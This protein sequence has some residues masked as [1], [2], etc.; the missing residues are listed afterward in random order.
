[1]I[2]LNLNLSSANLENHFIYFS[3]LFIYLPL[4]LITYKFYCLILLH[5]L[6][7]L[8][9][10]C[11]LIFCVLLVATVDMTL[12]SLIFASLVSDM[13]FI[14]LVIYFTLGSMCFKSLHS[15]FEFLYLPFLSSSYSCFFLYLLEHVE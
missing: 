6:S 2:L 8:C 13:L 7:M 4:I 1:M 3:I 9:N 15:P 10:F 12:S 14:P 11:S 5:S